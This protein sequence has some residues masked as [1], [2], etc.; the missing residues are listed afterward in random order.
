M[1]TKLLIGDIFPDT[2]S[3][4]GGGSGGSGTPQQNLN[5][6]LITGWTGNST[7]SDLGYSGITQSG[8]TSTAQ[9]KIYS[10]SLGFTTGNNQACSLRLN[11]TLSLLE[12]F[13]I[14]CWAYWTNFNY[15]GPWASW[16][17]DTINTGQ[18]LLQNSAGGSPA[19]LAFIAAFGGSY[20]QVQTTSGA[21]S[22]NTWYHIICEVDYLNSV[23]RMYLN[24]NSVNTSSI[25][26]FGRLNLGNNTFSLGGYNLG[27]ASVTDFQGYLNQVALFSGNMSNSEIAW[28]YNSGTGNSL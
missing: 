12:Q 6:R 2:S 22:T 8:S 21:I 20:A 24:G 13:S 15:A 5:S 14:S 4:G 18:I 28:L 26:G 25:S 1:A 23:I 16:S 7:N 19:T 9:T 11:E 3:G 10:S 17:S 27:A